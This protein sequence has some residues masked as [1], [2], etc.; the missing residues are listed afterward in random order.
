[1]NCSFQSYD[2]TQRD[3]DLLVLTLSFSQ[4]LSTYAFLKMEIL[5]S[6]STSWKRYLIMMIM[7]DDQEQLEV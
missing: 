2:L 4:P 5:I 3:Q 1:M 7:C 6:S